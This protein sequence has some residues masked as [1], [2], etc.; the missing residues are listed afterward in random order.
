M[1][2]GQQGVS[3]INNASASILRYVRIRAPHESVRRARIRDQEAV[4]FSRK[5]PFYVGEWGSV[6]RGSVLGRRRVAARVAVSEPAKQQED[7][8]D[9]QGRKVVEYPVAQQ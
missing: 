2:P 5:T 1:T 9:S 4:I 8:A 7:R 3:I 6:G